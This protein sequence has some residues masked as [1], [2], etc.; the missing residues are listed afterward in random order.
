[1][2]TAPF[3][4]KCEELKPIF[5]ELAVIVQNIEGLNIAMLDLSENDV[6]GIHLPAPPLLMYHEPW[7]E[8]HEILFDW[9]PGLILPSLKAWLATSSEPYRKAF[10]QEAQEMDTAMGKVPV[11]Q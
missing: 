10:S 11:G 7:T 2:Y 1:M 4:R 3:C 6:P 5:E 9:S 8:P